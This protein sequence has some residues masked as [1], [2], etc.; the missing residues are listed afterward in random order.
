M[1]PG[2]LIARP[3]V[4]L[5]GFACA[6]SVIAVERLEM[7]MLF[8]KRSARFVLFALIAWCFLWI[9][10]TWQGVPNLTTMGVVT[11][12]LVAS[13]VFHDSVLHVSRTHA[14]HGLHRFLR[15]ALIL[16]YLWLFAGAVVMTAWAQ[17][18]PAIFK[19]VLFHLFALGFIF[20]M[21]LGHAPLILPAA[22]G[23]P[24]LQKAP[25]IPFVIFQGA[26]FFRI[27][28]DFSLTRSIP[29]WQWSGW[30]TGIINVLSFFAYIALIFLFLKK[31]KQLSKTKKDSI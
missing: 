26:T 22:L 15:S 2:G 19:D 30:I 27:L 9:L 18:S 12:I 21:I 20:T 5:S 13:L 29:F 16:A 24:P 23:M 3:E 8:R 7:S 28:G 14:G 6:I 10:T 17:F 4:A 25:V 31:Q 1:F 11:L